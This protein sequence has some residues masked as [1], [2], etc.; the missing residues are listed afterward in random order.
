MTSEIVQ[1]QADLNKI[2]DISDDIIGGLHNHL[3]GDAIMAL[4]LTISRLLSPE[5]RREAAAD[6]AF[7]VDLIEWSMARLAPVEG[8]MN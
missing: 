8:G 3:T 5:V 2:A 4:A 6:G 7:I 1:H